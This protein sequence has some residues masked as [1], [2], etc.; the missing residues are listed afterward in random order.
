MMQRGN[1]ILCMLVLATLSSCFSSG[2]SSGGFPG[3]PRVTQSAPAGTGPNA[4]GLF[5]RES[6]TFTAS[7]SGVSGPYSLAWNFDGAAPNAISSLASSGESSVSVVFLELFASQVFM[8]VVTVTDYRG[9]VVSDSVIF[10]LN[11]THNSA[12]VIESLT[13]QNDAVFVTASDAD[14]DALSFSAHLDDAAQTE[15]PIVNVSGTSAE[16]ALVSGQLNPAAILTGGILPVVIVTVEDEHG[17]SVS[18]TL[19]RGSFAAFPLEDDTL[20]ALATSGHARVGD[21]VQIV[22]ATG[23]TA[24]PFKYLGGCGVLVENDAEYVDDSIDVGAPDMDGKPRTPIDGVWA[25]IGATDFL[26]SEGNGGWLVTTDQGDG[27]YRLDFSITPLD[28]SAVTAN[29]IL[30]NFELEF[31]QPGSYHL[32]FQ[33]LDV[34]PRT[35][36]T[37]GM[38][39]LDGFKGTDYFWSDIENNHAYNTINVE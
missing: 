2:G 18:D 29:G 26:V 10:S 27:T 12:P 15:L 20:Y 24:H 4:P 16:F 9:V 34:V 36:Y 33:Q 14:G 37:D 22:I 8:A 23:D 3:G 17:A 32:D 19:E 5:E 25:D 30:F 11:E 1:L 13:F 39:F 38:D 31:T 6:A 21:K 7:V 35:W 28:G